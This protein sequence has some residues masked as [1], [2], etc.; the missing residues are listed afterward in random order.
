MLY[1]LLILN[2]TLSIIYP[3]ILKNINLKKINKW[4]FEK[5][6]HENIDLKL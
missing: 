4:C 5:I 1:P 6:I 3:I 2:N